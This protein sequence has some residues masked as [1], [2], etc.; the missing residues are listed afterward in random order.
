M[1]FPYANTI[2]VTPSNT[3]DLKNAGGDDIRCRGLMIPTAGTGAIAIVN[4]DGTATTITGL[5]P[6]VIHP[7]S[8]TRIRATGTTATIIFAFW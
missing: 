5:N 8:T 7:I 6:D 1:R 3:E 4:E 2:Q